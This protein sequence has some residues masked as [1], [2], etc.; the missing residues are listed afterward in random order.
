MCQ[1]IRPTINPLDS[2]AHILNTGPREALRW[3]RNTS[4]KL[5]GTATRESMLWRSKT[6]TCLHEFGG[7]GGGGHCDLHVLIC[8]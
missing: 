4:D 6:L 3:L 8:C 5:S 1:Y 2:L 7:G